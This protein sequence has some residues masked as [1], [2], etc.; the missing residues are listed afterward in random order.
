MRAVRRGRTATWLFLA[1]RLQHN[2]TPYGWAGFAIPPLK[3]FRICN[4]F[5]R[6]HGF[7]KNE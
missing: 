1:R 5:G 3:S 6:E 7:S 2:K 4:P